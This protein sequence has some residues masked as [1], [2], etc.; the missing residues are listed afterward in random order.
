V[1]VAKLKGTPGPW[2]QCGRVIIA[3]DPIIGTD[4]VICEADMVSADREDALANARLLAAAPEL[5]AACQMMVGLIGP[6]DTGLHG[7]QRA[8]RDA[9]AKAI[10]GR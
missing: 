1:T 2:R 9:I 4:M 5:L 10:G 6:N 8:M 3:P 7:A